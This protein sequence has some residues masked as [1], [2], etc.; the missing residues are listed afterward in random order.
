MHLKRA[1][2]HL[3]PH[4]HKAKHHCYEH[5]E[6][7]PTQESHFPIGEFDVTEGWW[8]IGG[9]YNAGVGIIGGEKLGVFLKDLSHI[10]LLENPVPFLYIPR[11][12][13]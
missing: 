10:K 8:L 3:L 12:Q 1:L 2:I 4:L 7:Q 9:K 11:S 5:D 13:L 6:A